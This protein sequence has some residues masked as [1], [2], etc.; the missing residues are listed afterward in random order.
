[1]IAKT[2]IYPRQH[3]A[4]R[5]W[6][7]PRRMIEDHLGLAGLLWLGLLAIVTAIAVANGIWGSV[8]GSYW[9]DAVSS[10]PQW[11]VAFMAGYLAYSFLPAMIAHGQ[12]RREFR[13]QALTYS[14]VFSAALA[15]LVVIGFALEAG[16]FA[17]MD[18]PHG[19]GDGHLFS[20]SGAVHLIFAEFLLRFLVWSAAGFLIGAGFYR[21]EEAGWTAL[22]IGWIPVAI[23]EF[24]IGTRSGSPI[25][26]LQTVWEPPSLHPVVVLAIGAAA[27]L[28]ASAL[29]WRVIRDIPLR[30][31]ST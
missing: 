23:V 31:K 22:G 5:A 8:G 10:V 19:I 15:L 2:R 3:T 21:S 30:N 6:T 24:A 13:N 9:D 20:S 1:M 28:T 25:V 7:F 4:Q 29:A 11:F 16:L 14:V 12:T 18:W 27:F 26:L 17:V